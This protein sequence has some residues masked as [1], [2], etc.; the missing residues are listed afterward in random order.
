MWRY[1]NISY[2]QGDL[3]GDMQGDLQDDLQGYPI[4]DQHGD[5]QVNQQG[6]PQDH[7]ERPLRHS[8]PSAYPSFPPFFF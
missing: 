5:L 6:Y 7:L 2:M 1:N 4:G 3:Q 8:F